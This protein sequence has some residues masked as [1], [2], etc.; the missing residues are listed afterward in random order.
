MP[1]KKGSSQKTI[2]SNISEMIHAGHPRDQAIAAALSTARKY[3]KRRAPGGQAG[4]PIT[5]HAAYQT[6]TMLFPGR[7][8]WDDP[9]LGMSEGQWQPEYGDPRTIPTPP[10]ELFHLM[11]PRSPTQELAA[12]GVIGDG[13][14]KIKSGDTL[15][16]ISKKLGIPIP[17]L[18]QLN[19]NIKNP[20][21]IRAGD[22]LTWKKTPPPTPLAKGPIK[23]D[24]GQGEKPLPFV[25]GPDIKLPA[26]T[27]S[28]LD[29]GV[30]SPMAGLA[31]PIGATAQSPVPP[32]DKFNPTTDAPGKAAAPELNQ[33]WVAGL[34]KK[35]PKM[36]PM[37]VEIVPP[38]SPPAPAVPQEDR[39]SA[40][41]G[42]IHNKIDPVKV[43]GW[44]TMLSL[45][46]GM[47]PKG[48]LSPA[49]MQE[50]A[51]LPA[52]NAVREG[53]SIGGIQPTPAMRARL[54]TALKKRQN[55]PSYDLFREGTDWNNTGQRHYPVNTPSPEV[56]PFGEGH[57]PVTEQEPSLDLNGTIP[58]PSKVWGGTEQLPWRTE[59][60]NRGGAMRSPFRADGGQTSFPPLT[61]AEID[62]LRQQLGNPP[63]VPPGTVKHASGGQV[64]WDDVQRMSR[65]ANP[66]E[67]QRGQ[68]IIQE[69]YAKQRAVGGQAQPAPQHI[70]G[71]PWGVPRDDAMRIMD[72][73]YV[74]RMMQQ[75][76]DIYRG[77]E[78]HMAS[79]GMPKVPKTKGLNPQSIFVTRAASMGMQKKA[80]GLLHSA[81]PGR[82]D[83]ISLNVP[84]GSYVIPADV[85]AGH[86][87]GN[88]IAGGAALD[89]LFK[90]GPY[91]AGAARMGSMGSR[92]PSM[93]RMEKLSYLRPKTK[94]VHVSHDLRFGRAEGGEAHVPVMA[95]GG[96]YIVDPESVAAVGGG[97]SEK[98]F[99]ILD[100]FVL[101][102]RKRQ[103]NEIKG[104]KPPKKD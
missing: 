70:T 69:Q 26:V 42:T 11:K 88:T 31:N 35:P 64:N 32:S 57:I 14:Y 94:N 74:N 56:P 19:P 65:S 13:S 82:T 55:S 39:F 72:A 41:M 29:T 38:P 73:D 63:I 24:L 81:I 100:A 53:E 10:N 93:P 103:V 4:K 102:S 48:A 12:G 34:G 21:K 7:N 25:G 85:V 43:L 3:R 6:G 99:R 76:P 96:E 78:P 33:N 27:N 104:L 52:V 28:P 97:D 51:R 77:N 40:L 60:Y 9:V 92:P 68:A 54:E 49:V 18:M 84:N 30:G 91:G 50:M 37:D 15:S 101:N 5:P 58:F 59:P 46:L 20:D 61:Q 95:A 87:Q 71:A 79:G 98:G 1:L 75:L 36:P 45:A 16:G 62:Q 8:P 2:S 80:S 83:K 67:R 17:A 90:Q 86:G 66:E 47:A 23:G 89:K 22:V 44:P